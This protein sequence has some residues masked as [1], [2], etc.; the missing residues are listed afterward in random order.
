MIIYLPAVIKYN[1][2]L[3]WESTHSYFSKDSAETKHRH[4]SQSEFTQA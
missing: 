2:N 3:V 4:N 1:F